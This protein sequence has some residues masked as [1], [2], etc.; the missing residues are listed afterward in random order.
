V[1]R[2]RY[3]ALREGGL[4]WNSLPLRLFVGGN[5]KFWNPA[6]IDFSRD[7]AYWEQLSEPEHEIA[8]ALCAQFV[9]GEESVTQDIQPFMRAMRSEGRLADEMY[10]TQFA[11]EEAKHVEVFRRWLDAVGL[12]KDLSSYVIA[13]PA[14]QRIF[15]EELPASLDALATDP[16]PAAQVRA[17]ATYHHVVEGMLALTGYYAWHKI[18]VE[19]GILPGMQELV[20][21]IGDDERRHMAWGTFTCR[22][23]VAAD[24]ANWA[25]FENRMTELVP[26]AMQSTVEFFAPFAGGRVPFGLVPD[27]F[28]AHAQHKGLRRIGTIG[29]ARN[30]PP[31]EIDLDYAPMELEETFA[32]EDAQELSTAEA[33]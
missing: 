12:T 24:D 15:G 3:A 11:F 29:S 19:H 18:C 21:R 28:T 9:A 1:G 17:S 31:A 7:R 27:E 5:A 4:N 14:Y 20:R 10:L 2:N 25:V 26:M 8:T 23:H 30:R 13:T 6:D 16:S 32:A 22:R 33:P